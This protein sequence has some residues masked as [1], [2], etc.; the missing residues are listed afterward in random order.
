[1]SGEGNEFVAEPENKLKRPGEPQNA[2]I[3]HDVHEEKMETLQPPDDSMSK[4]VPPELMGM[5]GDVF[6][7]KPLQLDDITSSSQ[8]EAMYKPDD[9]VP[10]GGIDTS[11]LSTDN[12]KVTEKPSLPKRPDNINDIKQQLMKEVRRFGRK[13]EKIFKLL[14]GVQGPPEVKK[15]LV[16]FTIKEAA[17]WVEIGTVQFL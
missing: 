4:S 17:R 2:T 15:Q 7:P 13:Y 11:N 9:D 3:V 14:E 8:D 12:P 16:E 6:P 5:A 10:V 1:M